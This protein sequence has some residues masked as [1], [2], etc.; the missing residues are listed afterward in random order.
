ML[1]EDVHNNSTI[2]NPH[3]YHVDT[4]SERYK[5][6][7]AY[8]LFVIQYNSY[9]KGAAMFSLQTVSMSYKQLCDRYL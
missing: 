8:L 2:K 9:T 5:Y 3:I 1:I 7:L 4:Y 6:V